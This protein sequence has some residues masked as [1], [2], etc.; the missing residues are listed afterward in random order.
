MKSCSIDFEPLFHVKVSNSHQKAGFPVKQ[1]FSLVWLKDCLL[2]YLHHSSKLDI[3]LELEVPKNFLT[4]KL[5]VVMH[6]MS[7]VLLSNDS[8][9]REVDW[10]VQWASENKQLLK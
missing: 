1:M 10:T 7:T 8:A 6:E 2:L 9:D 3:K 5:R 4:L